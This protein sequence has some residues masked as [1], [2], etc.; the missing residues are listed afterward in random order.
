MKLRIWQR[1]YSLKK[2]SSLLAEKNIT[3]L[4]FRKLKRNLKPLKDNNFYN[5]LRFTTK[6]SNGKNSA[7]EDVYE[8]VSSNNPYLEMTSTR[9]IC[10]KSLIAILQTVKEE[11]ETSLKY[12]SM[13]VGDFTE[14]TVAEEDN[15]YECFDN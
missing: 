2:P 5:F 11:Q 4:S 14:P 6:Y 13:E 8:V 1:K 12:E 3:M 9:K 10:E 15:I 7:E